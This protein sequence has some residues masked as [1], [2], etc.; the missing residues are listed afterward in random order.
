MH[1]FYLCEL[2]EVI[3]GGINLYCT[4]LVSHNNYAQRHMYTLLHYFQATAS[5]P[6]AE[7]TA[8]SDTVT[9]SMNAAVL[10][11]E[12]SERLRKRKRYTVFTTEQR[13]TIG[14]YASEHRNAAAVKKFKANIEGGQFGESIVHF[15]KKHY[16]EEL[17]KAKHS[18]A[19]VPEVKSIASRI[20]G[21]LLTLGDV[22]TKVQAY[23]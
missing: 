7:E 2:C 21:R 5:L 14:K 9:Q 6:T 12:H 16:F 3:S 11:E 17:K 10:H 23:L 1:K 20:R 22:D 8:L 15:F 13:A 4:K 18:G 19:T